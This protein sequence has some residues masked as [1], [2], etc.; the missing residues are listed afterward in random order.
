MIS[1]KLSASEAQK[2][3]EISGRPD[4]RDVGDDLFWDLSCGVLSWDR[5]RF[6]FMIDMN[7]SD[8]QKELAM[9][10]LSVSG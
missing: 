9:F 5:A 7:I 3:W 8:T 6:S 1:V 10:L 2:L 4:P